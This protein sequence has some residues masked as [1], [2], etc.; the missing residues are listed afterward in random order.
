MAEARVTNPS[1][2]ADL[3]NVDR[4]GRIDL[5]M[6]WFRENFEDPANSLPYESREGGYQWIWGGPYDASEELHD[7]FPQAEDDEIDTAVERLE[8]NGAN[9]WTVASRRIVDGDDRD[10]SSFGIRPN[11]AEDHPHGSTIVETILFPQVVFDW[12]IRATFVPGQTNEPLGAELSSMARDNNVVGQEIRQFDTLRD[13]I[14]FMLSEDHSERTDN[15]RVVVERSLEWVDSLESDHE[16][17]VDTSIVIHQSPLQWLDLAKLSKAGEGT[18]I[19]TLLLTAPTLSQ[20][21]LLMMAYGGSRIF[22]SFVKGSSYVTT[23]FFE[24][25]G[26]R[27]KKGELDLF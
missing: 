14:R 2:P 22:L 5:M 3:A 20:G 11:Q 6:E 15:D 10:P 4:K 7:A 19:S 25:I 26:E 17:F 24:R 12:A 27:I 16:L 13:L 21:A 18:A 23:A 9:E 1:N 8:S